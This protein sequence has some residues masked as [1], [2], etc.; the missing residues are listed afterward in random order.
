VF[1]RDVRE[2]VVTGTAVTSNGV[3]GIVAARAGAD[4][5]FEDVT[6]S[7][8]GRNGLTLDGTPLALGP[9]ATGAPTGVASGRSVKGGTFADNGRYGIEVRGGETVGITGVAVT[10]GQM[11]IVVG[12][13]ASDVTISKARVDDPRRHGIAVRDDAA[14]IEVKDNKI[15]GGEVGIYV[16]RS[17]VSITDNAVSGSGEHGMTLVGSLRGSRVFGNDVSGSGSGT[18]AIDW[19]RALNVRV[20]DNLVDGWVASRSLQQILTSVLQPLTVLWASILAVVALAVFWRLG[21]GPRGV[22]DPQ[23]EP[24]QSMSRGVF[25]RA[26]AMRLRS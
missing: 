21:R 26:E 6:A 17:E 19:T 20:E 18:T 22:P 15:S 8:N 12:D 14:G 2:S 4:L 25:D 16:R 11:G 10:G 13:A 3:D 5:I 7:S 1:G 24:L 23:R 9:N